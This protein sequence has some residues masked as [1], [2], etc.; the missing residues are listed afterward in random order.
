M[1]TFPGSP[2]GT[3]GEA[4][5]YYFDQ[6]VLSK[7]DYF[8]ELHGGDIPESLTPF[9]IYPVTGDEEVDE[10]SRSMAMVYNIPLI[11]RGRLADPAR[12]PRSAFGVT[13][14][15]G[16][17]AILAESG[18]QGVL[19]MEEV[20]THLVGLRNMLIHL[21]M[22]SGQIVNTVKRT[23]LDGLPAARSELDGMWYPAISLNDVVKKGQVVGYI[24][25]YFGQDIAEVK[26]PAD[27][28]VR[29]VRTSPVAKVGN[30]LVEYGK[31]TGHEGDE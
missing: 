3:Y 13:A 1:G 31:I 25:D 15:R 18:Q 27:A 30:V 2:V 14:M 12:P 9:I 4:M 26:A 22:M 24:R 20:E 19:R 16:K 17:P 7:A 23:F 10:K 21:G 6:E 11:F 8:V 29:M 5:A 28:L